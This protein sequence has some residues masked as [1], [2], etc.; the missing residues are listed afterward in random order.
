MVPGY[1]GIPIKE[2]VYA[3]MRYVS[4]AIIP[5][6]PSPLLRNGSIEIIVLEGQ[7]RFPA[8]NSNAEVDLAS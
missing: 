2:V 6:I 7:I 8:N 3:S 1:K 4:L 5:I